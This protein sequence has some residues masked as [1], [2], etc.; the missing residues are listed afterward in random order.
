MQLMRLDRA[1]VTLLPPT[2]SPDELTRVGYDAA[3]WDQP[4]N[5]ARGQLT[6]AERMPSVEL[7]PGRPAAALP[8]G[9]DLEVGGLTFTDPLT[10]RAMTGDQFLDRR[11][12]TDALAV[13]Q[14]GRLVY[15]TYRNGMA[16]TDR[17]VA[18][19]CSKTLTTMMVGVAIAEGRL[20]RSGSMTDYVPELAE[21]PA[22]HPVTLEHVLDM[23][24][25]IDLEEHYEDADSMYWRYADAVGYYAD[26]SA[27]RGSTLAFATSEL[28]R[29]AEPPGVRF[30]YGSYLTN[31]LPIALANVYGVPAVELYEDRIYRLIGAE[32][33]ALVN[34]DQDRNP[35]V[36]GQVNLTLRDFVRWGHLL[37]DGGRSLA[38]AQVI[39]ERWVEDTYAPS[40]ARAAAFARGADGESMPGVEYHNQAWVLEPGR[41]VTML[42]IHG[43]FCW[44]DRSTRTVIVGFSSYPHQTHALLSATM[45]ELWSTIRAAL[46]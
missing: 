12:H 42:G 26:G 17:H 28:T 23:A 19:S 10:G 9:P 8:R 21:V 43:Q 7:D 45:G 4:Q 38:G 22:W 13:M 6:T 40:A 3:T 34:L 11:L 41:V 30:N 18:H 15:E 37:T 5:L 1:V 36:E 39:P 24:T 44:V 29:T 2:G 27:P 33:P 20:E 46:S 16:E 35:I 32:Q 14:D 25:G 31:L